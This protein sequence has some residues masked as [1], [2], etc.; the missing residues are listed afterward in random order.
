M[1]TAD[2]DLLLHL[3]LCMLGV[4]LFGLATAWLG[5]LVIRRIHRHTSTR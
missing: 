2:L 4:L 5:R 3:L 1:S